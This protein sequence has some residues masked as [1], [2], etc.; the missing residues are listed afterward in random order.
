MN[1]LTRDQKII[2]AF[3]ARE[4][5]LVNQYTTDDDFIHFF[6]DTL[7]SL[8]KENVSV[9]VVTGGPGS[10]KSTFVKNVIQLLQE[11]GIQADSVTTEDFNIHD[12]STRD[13]L[14]KNGANP[15][16]FKDFKHL[17][18]LLKKVKSGETI[19]VPVYDRASGKA[20]DLDDHTHV[21]PGHLDFLFIEGDFQPVDNPDL[22]IYFHVPTNV[23]RENRTTR[24]LAKHALKTADEVKESFDFRL[25]SQYYPYTL[26]HHTIAD[27]IIN[28]SAESRKN[29]EYDFIYSY[30]IHKRD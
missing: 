3:L 5:T 22:R 9:I 8:K 20:M 27:F 17:N 16:D 24:D 28:V 2:E 4:T 30:D 10:G 23:R 29:G 12:R 11:R 13:E 19:H 26:P 21:I 18:D 25:E 6:A 14:I 15:L 1:D 7:S